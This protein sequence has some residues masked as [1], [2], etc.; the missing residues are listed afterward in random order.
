M[1][2]KCNQGCVPVDSIW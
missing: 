1:M 2:Q